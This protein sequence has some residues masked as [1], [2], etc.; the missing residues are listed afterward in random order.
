MNFFWI[1]FTE[2]EDF[3]DTNDNIE[4]IKILKSKIN[5]HIN[6]YANGDDHYS[7]NEDDRI[8][9]TNNDLTILPNSHQIS[10]SNTDSFV[11]NRYGG[12]SNT[13]QNNSSMNTIRPSRPSKKKRLI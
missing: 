1:I 5:G 10:A 8:I 12:E 2:D 13:T 4:T 11:I 9:R 3:C 6:G 7:E